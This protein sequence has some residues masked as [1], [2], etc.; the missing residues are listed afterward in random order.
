M[1]GNPFLFSPSNFDFSGLDHYRSTDKDHLA[2]DVLDYDKNH[3]FSRNSPSL[4][5]RIHFY[6]HKLTTRKQIGLFSGRLKLF[7]LALFVLITF[8][9]IH[10]PIPFS[11][12][13]LGSHVKYLP[14]REKVDPEEAL[15]LHGLD[16]S[17][18][19]LPFFNDDMM[20]EFNYDPRL[21]TALILKLVLDHISVRNGTFD[22]KFK[23]PFNWKLWVDLHSRL[24]P[25]NSWYNRFRLPSGRFETCD[26]FKRFFGITKNHFGT[27]L[28]N[29][30]DI[31]YDTPEGYPKFKVLH[32]EDKAL[33][34]EAR[35]I[36]GASYLYHEAQNPKRLIFLGLGKSNESLILPVEANDSSNLMQF[37]HEYARSFNDQP[38]VS[39]E[40]LV[41]KVSLTLNLNS[42]KVLPINELDVIKDTPR[43]MNHNNQGLSIDKSSFQWDL[44]R[45]LQLLEHRTSQVNDVEGL[46]A[47]I[48]STIQC[49]MRS[50][51]DFSKYFHESKVSGKYLP[52]GEHYDWRFFNGFY[53]SQQENLAVLHR[54]GRAWLRFSR[55]AGLH[56]WIAHGTLLGW[57]WNGLILPWDQDL[58]VQMTVQSLYLLGRNFN[59][60]LVTD[61][62]IEDGYSSALGHYYID[63]GSSFFVRDKLNGNNAIDARFVDTETGLYVDITALAFTDHLK[64]KLTTKEKVEL[65]KVMDPNVKEKLQWI[66]NKYSTATLPGVIETDRN[67]VSDALEKQFHDFKFDNFVNKELF[68]CRN[69]HF[70]K[71]GEVGRLRS[72]MFEGVPALIPFEFESIL[73]REYPK[74]LTLKH[75]SNHF[76][77]PVNRLW[78]PEKKKKI[79]HI[80]FSLTKEVTESH[81]KELAQI[82]GNET[83]ITSD[84]AYSPFRIDPWLSRYRKKMTRS[85]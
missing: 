61:V 54:L 48:Y 75:F 27:D 72:T 5:S 31:E 65:Q 17:V 58:D 49:E 59:S 14:L 23:V 4:K 43:L 16:L 41:K 45:E 55:A 67:K 81:K 71:Y 7:V 38:F 42:D 1:S 69:N 20:S 85:Q 8:S 18:A 44:E 62:S 83:G 19:E 34:Y 53:L 21:P 25:S 64:L 36:Y 40:E 66:K 10:I 39:L 28:D 70:Y 11:L 3:F 6:R 30:V 12:D 47:G 76:W 29:C 78:V 9:A 13:I 60:S 68:H 84:F 79:R 2:L 63:V 56:T 37:N 32:A 52:S 33:P 15:H 26:E 74:G 24:V 35:I 50:M 73:K 51:Y 22:A 77:D 82:H 46:D 80:E 57:Y